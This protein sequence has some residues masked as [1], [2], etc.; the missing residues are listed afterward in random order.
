MLAKPNIYNS[1]KFLNILCFNLRDL[2][3]QLKKLSHFNNKFT[4]YKSQTHFVYRPRFLTL[5]YSIQT[6]HIQF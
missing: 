6:L 3:H 2:E 4:Y 1:K 5:I